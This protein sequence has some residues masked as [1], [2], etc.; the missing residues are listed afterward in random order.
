MGGMEQA[1][2]RNQANINLMANNLGV[3]GGLK[4]K[5]QG[6]L[7]R[8][9][10]GSLETVTLNLTDGAREFAKMN[11]IPVSQLMGDVAGAT[12]EFA[13]FGKDGGKN[14]LR[15]YWICLINLVPIWVQSVVLLMVY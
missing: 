3:S 7:S 9:N 5:L 12:E 8:L 14:I 4:I 11:N 6:A 1:S 2:F 15:M 10:G 13:L